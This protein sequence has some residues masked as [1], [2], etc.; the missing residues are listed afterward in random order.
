VFV[1]V[2]TDHQSQMIPSFFI[3]ELKDH[4]T[5]GSEL[6]HVQTKKIKNMPGTRWVAILCLVSLTFNSSRIYPKSHRDL[7]DSLIS[8]LPILPGDTN[9]AYTYRDISYY[10]LYANP[11][12][13]LMFSRR[14]YKLARNLEFIPGQ[15]WN[16]N[17][18]GYAHEMNNHFDSALACYRQ[19]LFLARDIADPSTEARML[20]VIGTAYY[21]K[22]LLSNALSLYD[23]SLQIFEEL[24]DAEGISQV[25]NNLG[26]VY[27]IRRNY[28]RAIEIYLRSISL[29]QKLSDKNGEANT[30]HNLGHVYAYTGHAE[31]SLNC[32]HKAVRIHRELDNQLEVAQC[33]VGIGSALYTLGKFNEAEVVIRN[34]LIKLPETSL[35]EYW[36]G[37][38]IIGSLEVMKGE[39]VHGLEKMEHAH[40]LIMS[41]GRLDMM[42]K[43]EKELALAY[44]RAGLY[45]QSVLHW[46]SY[47]SLADSMAGEQQQWAM[48]EMIARYESREKENRILVQQMELEEKTLKNKLFLA[49]GLFFVFL[50]VSASVY[51]Y[52]RLKVNKKLRQAN[53][54]TTTA[55][56]EKEVLLKE[57][58][59][60]VKNNLQMLNSL[61]N[62]QS[63]EIRDRRARDV[64]QSNRS[65]V[66]SIALIHQL[67]YT[68]EDFRQIDMK[69]FAGNLVANCNQIY[70]LQKR[71]ISIS[72]EMESVYLDID[73]ATPIGLIINELI[74]N[75]I[76]HA[77]PSGRKGLIKVVLLDQ[78]DQLLLVISDDGQGFEADAGRNDSF[79]LKLIRTLAR[80]MQAEMQ[81]CSE[82]GAKVV[83]HFPKFRSEL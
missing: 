66:H 14:G 32:L 51:S 9:K 36:T 7:A 8:K 60:R 4:L 6:F 30:L 70:D 20:N 1:F 25:L 5:S 53:I 73:T 31:E 54:L 41:S 33:L 38:L 19:A 26:I 42:K 77:Y 43:A 55:L 21:Q 65:R 59:H 56:E 62:I 23:Q 49:T 58:H 22:G 82:N 68:R 13:A 83:F 48:E 57:M 78:G 2:D 17:Q 15:I 46:K 52:S 35:L 75:S 80:K 10:L 16:L 63:R 18:Q 76:K 61:L 81:I 39:S 40:H 11:D 47:V 12:S 64:V 28:D 27:R 50:F 71:G 3:Q 72:V 45:S 44:E 67:L 74:V 69:T 29:K 79:G 34:A 37:L 24:G